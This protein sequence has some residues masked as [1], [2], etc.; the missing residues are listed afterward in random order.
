MAAFD[1]R[2]GKPPLPASG[3]FTANPITMTA[4]LA[5]M[6]LLTPEAHANMDALGDRLR[7]GV[8]AVF[9]R[10]NFPG[11]VT[12]MG[13]L[14]KIH[15]HNRPISDYRRSEEHTSELQSLMRKSYAVFCLKKK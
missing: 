15:M 8:R 1:H 13:T 12:G 2:K 6:V 3:T 7:A 10:R 4:G 11:Q 5:T 9:E 14:F